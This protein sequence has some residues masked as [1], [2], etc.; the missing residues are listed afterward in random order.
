MDEYVAMQK[1]QD[2][3]AAF[4]RASGAPGG[5]G[6]RAPGGGV[7]MVGGI[8]VVDEEEDR[9]GAVTPPLQPRPQPQP[10][11]QPQPEPEPVAKSVPAPRPTPARTSDDDEGDW[12]EFWKEVP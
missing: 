2:A 3:E 11:P 5:G 9:P 1:Q 10:Q 7:T 6:D 4:V 8:P 12:S